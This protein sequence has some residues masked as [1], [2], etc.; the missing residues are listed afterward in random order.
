MVDRNSDDNNEKEILDNVESPFF[1]KDIDETNRQNEK[2]RLSHDDIDDTEDTQTRSNIHL[3]TEFGDGTGESDVDVGDFNEIEIQNSE[4]NSTNYYNQSENPEN[5]ELGSHNNTYGS[6]DIDEASKVE[7][8]SSG[9]STSQ[10]EINT[11]NQN[12]E[13][14]NTSTDA[15]ESEA[16][17]SQKSTQASENGIEARNFSRTTEDESSSDAEKNN[18]EAAAEEVSSSEDTNTEETLTSEEEPTNISLEENPIEEATPPVE[19]EN[20]NN[21]PESMDDMASGSED[22]VLS[23]NVLTNDNDVDGDSISVQNTG[24]FDTDHGSI[25]I[26]ADG[27]FDYTPDADY[28]GADVFE[29]TVTDSNGGTDTA[30]INFTVNAENDGPVINNVK[31]EEFENNLSLNVDGS[32]GDVAVLSELDDFPTEAITVRINFNSD[33]PPDSAETNGIS[34]VSYATP[35]SNNEFLLFAEPNGGF[36]AYINGARNSLDLGDNNLFD[37]ENHD[38]TVSWNS[39]NG[40]VSIYV[41]GNLTDTSTTSIGTPLTTGGTLVLGQEQDSVGGGFAS[42]QEFSGEI[43]SLEVYSKVLDAEEINAIT[44]IP[45]ENN[46]VLGFDFTDDEPLSNFAGDHTFVLDGNAHITNFVEGTIEEDSEGI[47]GQIF[48]NDVD[49]DDLTYSIIDE[50]DEGSVSIEADGTFHF[51]PGNDFQDLGVGDSREV[52]FEVQVS[53]GNGGID[54]QSITITVVGQNDGPAAETL[55]VQTD[56]ESNVTGQLVASDI[57]GDNLTFSMAEQPSEGLV[58][59]NA[60]GS[61]SFSPEN[62]FQDLG[63]GESRE[64]SFSYQVSDDN[65]GTSVETVTIT[66]NGTNDVPVIGNIT[67]VVGSQDEAESI[68]SMAMSFNEDGRSGDF[69]IAENLTNFPTEAITVELRFSSTEAPNPSDT[70][71]TSLFSYNVAGSDNEFLLFSDSSGSL[72]VYI[73][74]QRTLMDVDM[75]SLFDG[76]YH[77]LAVSW[78]SNN[79]EISVYVDGDLG[80][81][82]TAQVGNPINTGG[83]MTLGQE[84]D[85]LGGGFAT[86]QQFSGKIA[87]VQIFNEV[88]DAEL[89]ETDA[90]TGGTVSNDNSLIHAFNFNHSDDNSVINQGAGND[91][92][93]SGSIIVEDSELPAQVGDVELIA[94]EDNGV[95]TGSLNAN[96]VDGDDL[97]FSLVESPVEGT[98]NIGDDGQFTFDPGSDFQDLGVG[99]TR[100]VS[101]TYQIDDGNGG[102]ESAT[103]TVTV[104][105]SN[106][107]PVA[108]VD[109]AIGSEDSVLSGN[110]LTNDSDVD[111]DSLS[112]QNTGTFDTDHGSIT[113]NADGSF[114]YTPDA[115]FNGTDSFEVTVTDGT[116]TTTSTLNLNVEAVADSANLSL[117]ASTTTTLFTSGAEST[118]YTN[119]NNSTWING[120]Y[121]GWSTDSTA[122]EIHDT[123]YTGDDASEGSQWFELNAGGGNQDAMNIYRNVDTDANGTYEIS[124]DV[125][126]RP[127]YDA[128]VNSIEVYWDNELVDTISLDGSGLSDTDWQT[129][130]YTVEGDGDSA[131]FEFKSVGDEMTNGRG[132]FL[133]NIKVDETV[134]VEVNNVSG[135][136]GIAIDLPDI[137]ASLN[138]TD[139]SESLTLA[140]ADIPEGV[141]VSD[142]DG[143]TFTASEGSETVDVTDWSL[144]S[145]SIEAPVGTPDFELEVKATTVESSNGDLETITEVISVD[146]TNVIEGTE[147]TSGETVTI[148][149]NNYTSTD[150]GFT[151]T[152]QNIVDGELTSASASNLSTY[153]SG[154]GASGTVSDTDSGVM[155]Q[156]AYDQ[157]SGQSEQLVVLFDEGVSSA[158]FS[159]ANLYTASYGEQAHWQVFDNGELVSEGDFTADGYGGS[160]T[161]EIDP[162]QTFDQLVFTGLEQSDGSDGSDFM[163][164]E[165]NFTTPDVINDTIVGSTG[166]DHISGLSGN[167]VIAGGEGDDVIYGG[168]GDDTL[169][170]LAHQGSDVVDGGSGGSWTDTLQLDG[171]DG[172]TSQDGWTLNLDNGS[173]VAST[174]EEIGEIILSGDA[175]GTITFDDGGAIDFENIEK[176]VW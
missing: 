150:Q 146:L 138:D 100:E 113:I 143:N 53:D 11:N 141:T 144:N 31:F 152:A 140:I 49:G 2:N 168:D 9:R 172:Q 122:I 50:P 43:N 4:L 123:S 22:S 137:S 85:S 30:T 91:L 62:D 112:V 51:T 47:N 94:L 167:D 8:T 97:S 38:L 60:D 131:R 134:E 103:E 70:N 104:L 71:G 124:F 10:I 115:N 102:I 98:V 117:N 149:I 24:T 26:N 64:T 15:P 66:V 116:T 1:E 6:Q 7:I 12:A 48:A 69:A 41:D 17:A 114:D 175:G 87:D 108:T 73:N 45:S 27:S 148:D 18:E 119:T 151:V 46:P 58:S 92:D 57:D 80:D 164:T 75:D 13:S 34:L 16:Y 147:G 125:S 132:M 81:T 20:A 3:S 105:G 21:V 37:G 72:G 78:D 89:I 56:E 133:D 32:S 79:G 162:G 63:V 99:E 118:D 154:F 23:G 156:I 33:T 142:S 42:N 145:L 110:V 161:V 95:I 174:D 176:I 28:N 128:D 126:P 35:D 166:D 68:A 153:G 121:D 169:T 84:Q 158:D 74:G 127:G 14:N 160:G 170:F 171:F 136:T 55:T 19:E 76:D 109:M 101:F 159:F 86:N 67:N 88:R 130:T 61:F 82:A 54:T 52:S 39:V 135:N 139:G 59:I 120:D 40:E 165:V 163:I 93:Y 65:G 107:G 44:D 90:N 25:T 5:I 83:T 96:D 29:Y 106:D 111:G 129:F 155:Q 36:S 77:H 173:T 157:D